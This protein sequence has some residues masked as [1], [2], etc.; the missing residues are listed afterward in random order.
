MNEYNHHRI[1]ER[2][3]A[4][5]NMSDDDVKI[6]KEAS[7]FTDDFIGSSR[8]RA[9]LGTQDRFFYYHF[10]Y[11]IKCDNGTIVLQRNSQ[12]DYCMEQSMSL[13]D[14]DKNKYEE[15]KTDVSQL[16]NDY[17][18]KPPVYMAKK[19]KLFFSTINDREKYLMDG[20]MD[21]SNQSDCVA[22]LHAMGP[23]NENRKDARTAF[24]E[25]LKKCFS[26]YLFIKDDKQALYILGIAFH[27]IMD[28]FT[29]SHTNFQQ[30][31]KQSM[32][33]H[34]QGDVIPIKGKFVKEKGA[35][36]FNNG[37]EKDL[38]TLNFIPGQCDKDPFVVGFI[39]GINNNDHI[40]DIEFF[41]LL[42]FFYISEIT[43]CKT[44]H[45]YAENWSELIKFWKTFYG[46]SLTE[47]NEILQPT[48]LV[49]DSDTRK[50]IDTKHKYRYGDNAYKYSGF[51]IDTIF[52]IYNYLK[53]QR[54]GCLDNYDYYKE[55]KEKKEDIVGKAVKKWEKNY[56][57]FQ[58][59]FKKKIQFLETL[60]MSFSD[61]DL[62][63][64]VADG[65]WRTIIDHRD[66]IVDK[67]VD[68]ARTILATDPIE[69]MGRQ[70][71]N[72]YYGGLNKI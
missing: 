57:K 44:N 36:K 32:A 15:L 35:W 71:M 11:D 33:L 65:L 66:N 38:E 46:R 10:Y 61:K 58:S 59:D 4:K 43:D 68:A 63:E 69:Q 24:S 41:M 5:V 60:F 6:L 28:S 54:E 20:F 1:I 56:E 30:Y 29:P 31:S 27:G 7:N 62:E 25:H 26:E 3:A 9:A 72:L 48:V 49:K 52:D 19:T 21:N 47:I 51:A 18:T 16:A 2:F 39:K 45:N 53:E 40:N 37:T 70:Q 22:F 12:N 8:K 13:C 34:A 42:I 64:S 67:V 50:P 23:T 55:N 14:Y 17:S